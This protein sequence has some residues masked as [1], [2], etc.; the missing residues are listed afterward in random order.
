[1]RTTR[2]RWRSTWPPCANPHVPH[3]YLTRSTSGPY[4]QGMTTNLTETQ[5]ENLWQ[6]SSG[7]PFLTELCEKWLDADNCHATRASYSATI[8]A[9]VKGSKIAATAQIGA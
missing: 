7:L 1:V 3:R 4:I 2:Q 8:L 9:Y 5:V 6:N